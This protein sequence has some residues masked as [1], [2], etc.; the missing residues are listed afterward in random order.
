MMF[1]SLTLGALYIART[2]PVYQATAKLLIELENLKVT[3]V[4]GIVGSGSTEAHYQ[5]QYELLRSRF[6][7]GM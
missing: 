2:Q 5:I 6:L 1:V 7:V 3:P 4:E